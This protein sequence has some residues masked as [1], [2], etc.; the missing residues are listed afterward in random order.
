MKTRS[1]G[2]ACLEIETAGLRIL[3]DPWWSGPAYTNQ[4]YPWPTPRPDGVD[5]R[6]VDYLYLS[7]GHEDHLHVPTLRTL[8]RGAVALVPE[9]LSG[10]MAGFLRD[11]LGFAQVIELQHGRTVEL[12][13]GL[14]ATCYVNLTDS[15]L[16]LESEGQVLVDANDALHASPAAVIDFFC[17]LLRKNHGRIDQLFVGFSGAAWYPNCL[18]APGKDDRAAAREREEHFG[19]QFVRIVDQLEP[20]VASAFAASFVLVEP[21]NRWINEARFEVATPDE[22][23]RGR[24]PGNR[25]RAHLLL[26]GD[27]IEDGEVRPGG[28]PRPSRELLDRSFA[29]GPLRAPA[30]RASQLQPLPAARLQELSRLVGERLQGSSSRAARRE[31][32]FSFQIALRENP[33]AALRIE[34][35]PEQVATSLGPPRP[36]DAQLTL[37]AEIFEALLHEPYGVESITIGYGAIATVQD[38]KAMGRVIGLLLRL[39]PRVGSWRG[40]AQ[41][42]L[43]NPRR[44]LQAL[45]SQRWPLGLAVGDRLGLLPTTLPPPPAT[46]GGQRQDREAA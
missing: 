18:R 38:P 19:D 4:W 30:E 20:R 22:K 15:L 37:R 33:D 1:I 17:K 6:P 5:E 34:V 28:H 32:P 14:R 40:V 35:G 16:V 24:R 42:L 7:H 36:S 46:I 26:P 45:L 39:S 11:E 2:H 25:T 31:P 3:T 29:D 10:S 9:L 41:E 23:F 8:R 44:S 27:V 12:R 43:R 13:N 21:H